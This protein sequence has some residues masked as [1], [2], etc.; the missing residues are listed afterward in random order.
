[1]HDSLEIQFDQLINEK[2]EFHEFGKVERHIRWIFVCYLLISLF[3]YTYM[4]LIDSF[5]N[6]KLL[7]ADHN[8]NYFF[9]Y[10]LG[11]V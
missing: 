4:H 9:I 3:Q 8:G 1:M 11:C 2:R 7:L 6:L 10:S 5:V